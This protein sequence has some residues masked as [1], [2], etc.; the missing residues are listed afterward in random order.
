MTRQRGSIVIYLLFSIVISIGAGYVAYHLI[1]E[2]KS[3]W[4]DTGETK[5]SVKRPAIATARVPVPVPE[6]AEVVAPVEEVTP[7]Q[8]TAMI[9]ASRAVDPIVDP[10]ADVSPVFGVPGIVG[11]IERGAVERRFK[12]RGELL[13]KCYDDYGDTQKTLRVTLQVDPSGKLM[14][15]NLTGGWSVQFEACVTAALK[16]NFSPTRDGDS[17]VIVQPIAFP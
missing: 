10:L 2:N 13:Q 5:P 7:Q 6:P 4:A 15:V 16:F 8:T 11:G 3:K 17:A 12:P 1:H 9:A 14:N